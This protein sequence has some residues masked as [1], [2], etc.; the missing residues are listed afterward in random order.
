MNGSTI[1]IHKSAFGLWIIFLAGALIVSALLLG[2]A[3]TTSQDHLTLTDTLPRLI[4]LG[5]LVVVIGTFVQAYVYM[6]SKVVL[7]GEELR[8][9][10]WPTLFY[11]NVAVCECRQ[12]QDVD[13]KKG[14]ILS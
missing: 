8:F 6:L 7:D 13:V 4:I 12:V 14:G 1:V 10:N 2:L 9:V 11:S 5:I 3:T